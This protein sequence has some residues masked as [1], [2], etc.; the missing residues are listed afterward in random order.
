MDNPFSNQAKPSDL[1]GARDIS[2][3]RVLQYYPKNGSEGMPFT[4]VLQFC[5]NELLKLGF[6]THIVQDTKQW[7]AHG[8]TTLSC[9]I[10][11][12]SAT[13]WF[14]NKV[15]V[16]ILAVDGDTVLD[17]WYF[18]E[19]VFAQSLFSNESDGQLTGIMNDLQA[20]GARITG[21]KNDGEDQ[22]NFLNGQPE[23]I[24][25]GANPI[26]PDS[27]IKIQNDHFNMGNAPTMMH[28][29]HDMNIPTNISN[30]EDAHY[31]Q[32]NFP[33]S[34]FFNSSFRRGSGVGVGSE[35]DI[36]SDEHPNHDE[37]EPNLNSEGLGSSSPSAP[38][39][40][41]YNG[42]SP[43]LKKASL[44]FKGHLEEMTRNWTPE[45][46]MSKRRLV[47]FGRSHQDNTIECSFEAVAPADLLPNSIVVSCIYWEQKNDF[48]ITSVD[49]IYL[50]ESLIA[51][52]FTVEEKNRIRR[53]LEGFRPLTISKCKQECADFFKLI[54]SFPNPKPRNIEKDVK[55]FPWKV[56]PDA[57]RKIVGKY[58]FL[59]TASYSSTASV[60]IDAFHN[61]FPPTSTPKN[62]NSRASLA[63]YSFISPSI[64]E[65]QP[66]N[67]YNTNLANLVSSTSSA[68]V[69]P[70]YSS[71]TAYPQPQLA[72]QSGAQRRHLYLRRHSLVDPY[73]L[74]Y[75]QPRRHSVTDVESIN[76]HD[77]TSLMNSRASMKIPRYSSQFA[78]AGSDPNSQFIKPDAVLELSRSSLQDSQDIS[79][80][81]LTQEFTYG[82][83]LPHSTVPNVNPS[84]DGSQLHRLGM[85]FTNFNHDRSTRS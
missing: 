74:P 72:Q 83:G 23:S 68:K 78:V 51:V 29:Y 24:G 43:V 32:N 61:T 84:S 53:N 27:F 39:L 70:V 7:N 25:F 71:S 22:Y 41:N 9:M 55:V 8:Y 40:L 36:K 75:N 14:E 48:Y 20:K 2:R 54:M 76:Q 81:A 46:S 31:T 77:S 4:V 15:P 50:L 12:F 80:L 21:L 67:D 49:C 30:T 28:V 11:G 1:Q 3:P 52:R 59:Q 33:Q 35:F 63:N 73:A 45:E 6:G 16:C 79:P 17:S 69:D 62:P 64:Q 13:K 18:G 56:L 26:S 19:Y 82:G 37:N 5:P 66:T 57:L 60:D 44:T 58:R 65:A 47:Q 85:S 38:S 10:P 42:Y 34:T